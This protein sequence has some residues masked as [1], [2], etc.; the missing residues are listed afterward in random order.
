M[1]HTWRVGKE[2][3][4]DSWA[5]IGNR[6][7]YTHVKDA[8]HAPSSPLAMKDGWHYV[9]PGSGEL[10]LLESLAI[11]AAS[12]YD[13][14]LMFEHEKYWHPNLAEP[15][16]IFPQFVRWIRNLYPKDTA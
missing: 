9:S 4:A 13:G 1:G 8:V 14:W 11:L 10:P 2:K 12:G 7:G 6:V 16:D 3:P 5:A 15:E